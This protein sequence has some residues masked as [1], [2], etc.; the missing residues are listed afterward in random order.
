MKTQEI[1]INNLS[2]VRAKKENI[3]VMLDIIIDCIMTLKLKQQ[4]CIIIEYSIPK[5]L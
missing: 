1:D 5:I 4:K 2:F 3:G